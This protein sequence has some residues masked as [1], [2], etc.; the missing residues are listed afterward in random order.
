MQW[1]RFLVHFCKMKWGTADC[2]KTILAFSAPPA[3]AQIPVVFWDMG[4]QCYFS[5]TL[6]FWPL[7]W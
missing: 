4:H 7:N 5:N 6:H 2:V 3:S 1:G